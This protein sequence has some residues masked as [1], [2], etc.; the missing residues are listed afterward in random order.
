M[1]QIEQKQ[2]AKTLITHFNIGSIFSPIV[3][4]RR[5]TSHRKAKGSSN[6]S[7]KYNDFDDTEYVESDSD[8]AW[9]PDKVG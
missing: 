9:T 2:T 4:Q 8:P 5:E 7:I 1:N 3:P 6:S